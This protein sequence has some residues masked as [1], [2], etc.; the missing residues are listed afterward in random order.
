MVAATHAPHGERS[1]RPGGGTRAGANGHT[2]LVGQRQ[3]LRCSTRHWEVSH[4]VMVSTLASQLSR[5]LIL[6]GELAQQPG[7][8]LALPPRFSRGCKSTSNQTVL[9]RDEHRPHLLPAFAATPPPD[10]RP[11]AELGA[12]LAQAR[13]RAAT[14]WRCFRRRRRR[15]RPLAPPRPRYPHRRPRPQPTTGCRDCRRRAASHSP[16]GTAPLYPS[17]VDGPGE[18]NRRHGR[19]WFGNRNRAAV[20]GAG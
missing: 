6:A 7:K 20:P 10:A 1:R 16:P 12:H 17:E 5:I 13:L 9:R 11:D 4:C 15:R 2:V 14:G 3:P 18:P 19:R 8:Q